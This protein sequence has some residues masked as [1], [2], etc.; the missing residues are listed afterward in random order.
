MF[1]PLHSIA[2]MNL[3]LIVRN[4]ESIDIVFEWIDFNL[5]FSVYQRCYRQNGEKNQ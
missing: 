4:V 5:L 2:S 3:S 1:Y